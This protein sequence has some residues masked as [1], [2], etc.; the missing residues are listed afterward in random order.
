MAAH[1]AA[2]AARVLDTATK[3]GAQYA[4]VQFWTIRQEDVD[5][6]N[7]DV[8]NASDVSSLGYGV[9]A[10]VDGSWGF[11]GSDRLDDAGFDLTAARA[12]A[13]AAASAAVAGR[14]AAVLPAEKIVADYHTPAAIDPAGIGLSARANLLLEA[15]R[16]A[17]VAKN[18]VSAYA[19]MTL[20]TRPRNSIPRPA[21]RSRSCCVKRDRAWGSRRSART[22]TS[23]RAAVRAISASF[24][25]AATKWSSAR[26]WR[27]SHPST[28][29]KR[30]CWPTRRGCRRARAI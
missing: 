14:I 18:V 24:K 13:A 27:R 16:S 7:G 22:A 26:V 6:R 30:R 20:F 3:A 5:V 17:H 8:R 23:R 10:F 1:F 28:A 19:Y 15:E 2:A 29:A 21:A 12:T 9:R 4:D 25:A 11:C